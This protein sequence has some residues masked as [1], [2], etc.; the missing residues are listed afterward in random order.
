MVGESPNLSRRVQRSLPRSILA[1]SLFSFLMPGPGRGFLFALTMIW[2][3][4]L[5]IGLL[6]HFQPAMV[7]DFHHETLTSR[8]RLKGGGF[9]SLGRLISMY[10]GIAVCC[11]YVSGFL[12]ISFLLA[13]WRLHSTRYELPTGLGPA[14]N[15]FV[16]CLLVA[17]STIGSLIVHFSFASHGQRNDYLAIDVF[18]WYWTTFEVSEMRAGPTMGW[19]GL[20][21]LPGLLLI[22]VAVVIA[23]REFLHRPIPVPERVMIDRQKPVVKL[24]VGESIDEI[25]GL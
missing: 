3:C 21:L 14:I 7:L 11:F 22:F 2:S 12:S 10:S 13:K 23:A 24:P 15:L 17:L 4:G 20:L 1:R 8:G 16:G 18:N 19:F 6:T 5:V 25:L 9:S